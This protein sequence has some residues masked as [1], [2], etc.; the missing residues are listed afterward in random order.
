MGFNDDILDIKYVPTI[1]EVENTETVVN[2]RVVVATNSPQVRVF[3]LA[4]FSCVPL[5]G[6]ED[7]VLAVDASP[8][9]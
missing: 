1:R 5:D 2:E 8:D 9:G 3:D 7:I 6:H 4:G